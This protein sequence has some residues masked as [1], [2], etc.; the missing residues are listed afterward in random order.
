M[1]NIAGGGGAA[2]AKS[3]TRVEFQLNRNALAETYQLTTLQQVFNSLPNIVDHLTGRWLR[4]T[5]DV[6]NRRTNSERAKPSEDWARI[7]LAFQQWAGEGHSQQR[8]QVKPR[9]EGKRLLSQLVGC[10]TTYL[11][12]RH[13]EHG[14]LD[15]PENVRQ[16]TLE[17]LDGLLE[18][19]PERIRQRRKLLRTQ[20]VIEEP[21]PFEELLQEN[22]PVNNTGKAA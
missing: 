7:R 22:L 8:R 3:A 4:V 20:G 13:T 11:A 12:M 10:L 5:D 19:M 1:Y 16:A 17:A 18:E 21:T 14:P 6:V 9:P 15:T 2:N